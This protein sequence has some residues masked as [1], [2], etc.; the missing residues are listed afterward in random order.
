VISFIFSS[1]KW[2]FNHPACNGFTHFPTFGLQALRYTWN[3]D[4]QLPLVGVGIMA[5]VNVAWSM[6]VGAVLC[7]GLIWPLV[8]SKE[9]T[10][11]AK[12]LPV[13][14]PRGQLGYLIATAAALVLAEGAYYTGRGLLKW[15]ATL[16][17]AG[18]HHKVEETAGVRGWW[19]KAQGSWGAPG[20]LE[21]IPEGTPRKSSEPKAAIVAKH[22]ARAKAQAE[23]WLLRDDMSTGSDTLSDASGLQFSLVSMERSFRRAV[24]MDDALPSWIGFAGYVVLMGVAVATLPLLFVGTQLRAVHVVVAGVVAPFLAV[25]ST[26]AAGLTDL[27]L[28][29][30][31]MKFLVLLCAAWAASS[32]GVTVGLICGGVGLGVTTSAVNMMY[33]YS[34]GYGTMTH[35]T[36]VLVAYL[37]G[38]VAGCL[39]APVSLLYYQSTSALAD[40]STYMDHLNRTK[41]ADMHT[42]YS[43]GF[44]TNSS[45]LHP[46][47]MVR[48]M[49]DI[50]ASSGF[51]G[52]PQHSVWFAVAA[53]AAGLVLCV[54]ADVAPRRLKDVVP[55]PAAMAVSSVLGAHTAVGVVLGCLAKLLWKW[56]YPRSAE[57]YAL[58]VGAALIAGEGIWALGRGLLM[59]FAVLPPICMSFSLAPRLLR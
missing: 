47:A 50:G 30:V 58:I 12:D 53:F 7:W 29:D 45:S 35:P 34:A 43:Y 15:L 18:D 38:A 54:L 4:F 49:A 55:R 28:T 24:F 20:E 22:Q 16:V 37:I 46:A 27:P 42:A 2:I 57:A 32:G 56:P 25:G 31:C 5:P 9:G 59:A 33:A 10:W 48:T 3:F 51:D 17:G 41:V 14:D 19:R 8:W 21:Q 13:W 39:V 40:V 1:Y 26:R 23:G 11:Y 6:L 44:S 36:A 52:R